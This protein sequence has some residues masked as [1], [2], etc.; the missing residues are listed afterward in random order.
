MDAPPVHYVTTSDGYSIAYMDSGQ[1]RPLV[2]MPG[3]VTHIDLFWRS[4]AMRPVF[5][6]LADRFRLIQYDAR[7]QGLSMRGL[8]D[9][10]TIEDWELDIE[11]IVQQESLG[12]FVL[13]SISSHA[14]VAIRYVLRHPERVEALILWNMPLLRQ[15]VVPSTLDEMALENWTFFI[16]AAARTTF[17]WEEPA[18]ARQIWRD[19]W[20][21]ADWF[22][23]ARA[24]R[25]VTIESVLHQLQLPTLVIATRDGAWRF[26][27]EE[28]SRRIAALVPDS[29]LVVFDEPG[30]GFFGYG[31]Q[32]PPAVPVIEDFLKSVRERNKLRSQP[33][34]P[35]AVGLSSRE[36]EV[37]RLIAAGRSNQQIADALV[38]SPSTVLH[39]VTNILT[40]TGCSNRT[41]A[42]LY[43]RD[44]G[45]A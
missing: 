1:G 40:K 18:V 8:R 39:H 5:H 3:P 9:N 31:A 14:Y 15:T 27:T 35:M 29:R 20:A 38:I 30:G 43:A 4:Q 26:G 44:R 36:V 16:D 11:A 6:E 23:R 45:I 12:D 13:A 24:W 37:L 2:L 41:E 10:L 34:S 21:Q 17:P 25:N 42:A 32:T 28:D 19:T 33:A 7:G 22:A